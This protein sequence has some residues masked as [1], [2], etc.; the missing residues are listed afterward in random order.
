MLWRLDY[1][2]S[3]AI[4]PYVFFGIEKRVFDLN[5]GDVT[6]LAVMRLGVSL[7]CEETRKALGTGRELKS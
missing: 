2:N 3:P 7:E 5:Y 6:I 4:K 1:V